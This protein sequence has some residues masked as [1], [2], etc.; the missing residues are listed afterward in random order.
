MH[1]WA[2]RA[3]LSLPPS[4]FALRG[5]NLPLKSCTC[6]IKHWFHNIHFL[7]GFCGVLLICDVR[8]LKCR[9]S[10]WVGWKRGTVYYLSK[11]VIFMF[12]FLYVI[13]WAHSYVRYL[14]SQ[15]YGIG[16]LACLYNYTVMYKYIHVYTHE[17]SHLQNHY[18][19]VCIMYVLYAIFT[20]LYPGKIFLWLMV[21]LKHVILMKKYYL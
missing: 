4:P 15:W 7:G 16:Q 12:C 9:W 20:Y 8:A 19:N 13:Y 21:N 14:Y 6:I 17:P 10:F 11:T 2:L 5:Y 3:K 1:L 18:F